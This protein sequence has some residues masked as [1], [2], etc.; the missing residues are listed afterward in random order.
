NEVSWVSWLQDGEAQ[1]L[2]AFTERVIALRNRHP[3]FRRRT[4]FRGRAVRGSEAKDIVW[5]NPDG[6]EMTDDEWSQGFARCLGAHLSGHGLTERDDYGKPV[7]DDDLVLLINAHDDV[8]PFRLPP[9]WN[10]SLW[11][12]RLD[13]HADDGTPPQETL[14]PGTEYPLQ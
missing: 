4:F 11:H 10:G 2:L 1:G 14:A 8:I 5:L 9:A 3:L 6:G 13:T 12:A 7:E